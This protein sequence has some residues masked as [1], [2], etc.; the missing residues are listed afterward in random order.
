MEFMKISLL[1]YFLHVEITEE[2]RGLGPVC[3]CCTLATSTSGLADRSFAR[4][5]FSNGDLSGDF[6]NGD[7]ICSLVYS[8][9]PRQ[10]LC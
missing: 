1:L 8:A 2:P 10:S 7:L 6:S 3:L 9:V 5:D 4:G